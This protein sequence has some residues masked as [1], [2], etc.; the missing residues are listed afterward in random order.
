M[1]TENPKPNSVPPSPAGADRARAQ[2]DLARRRLLSVKGDPFL[3]GDWQRVLFLHYKLDPEVLRPYV[4]EPF[5]LEVHEGQ[6]CLSLVAL[7]MRHFRPA[8]PGVLLAWPF[9]LLARQR[10]LNVRTYARW[11]NEPGALFLWGW[12]SKPFGLRLPTERFGLSC[13][14]GF[15]EYHHAFE[16]SLVH[17]L[18]KEKAPANAFKYRAAINPQSDFGRCEPGSLAEFAMERYTGF[19]SRRNQSLLFRAWHAPW[20]QRPLEVTVEEDGLL[21]R[22]FSWFKEARL[23]GANFAPGFEQVWLGRAHRLANLEARRRG[24]RGALSAFYEM[25]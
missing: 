14:F 3:C 25:P 9:R 19:F 2:S 12:L 21:R 17:G 5:E 10:F 11:G 6:A 1:K 22:R 13:G 7:T 24:R 18:A 23:A 16:T 4:P 15:L 20:V 8:R